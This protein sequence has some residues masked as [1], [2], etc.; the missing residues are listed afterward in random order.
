[1][2]YPS[3]RSSIAKPKQNKY[4]KQTLTNKLK[5][6]LDNKQKQLKDEKLRKDLSDTYYNWE[7][8]KPYEYVKP[9]SASLDFDN[10]MVPRYSDPEDQ[11]PEYAYEM[12]PPPKKREPYLRKGFKM[13]KDVYKKYSNKGGAK[14]GRPRKVSNNIISSDIISASGKKH[15]KKNLTVSFN[16]F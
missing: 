15:N 3:R 2:K 6:Y 13:L 9:K 4:D 12:P 14:R 5:N 8:D 16:D 7:E 10:P 11:D 1:M